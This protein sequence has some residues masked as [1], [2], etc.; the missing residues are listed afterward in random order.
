[1]TTKKMTLTVGND[2]GNAAHKMIINGDLIKAP[3]VFSKIRKLPN[4]EELSFDYLVNNLDKN[5]IVSIETDS[6]NNGLPATYLIAEHAISSGQH[7]TNMEVR[8]GMTKLDS[9]VPIVNTNAQI[10]IYA[11]KYALAENPDIS[12]IQTEIYMVT[13][14]PVLQN[15]VE[16]RKR[17]ADKFYGK[18]NT[19]VTVH[20]KERKIKVHIEY[21]Y[22]KVLHENVS[23]IWYLQAIDKHDIKFKEF[24]T[25][26][27]NKTAGKKLTGDYFKGKKILMVAPGDGTCEYVVLNDVQF[28]HHLLD[29]S[30]NGL[31]H[32]IEKVLPDFKEANRLDV[33]TRQDFSK[34]MTDKSARYHKLVHEYI[35]I[36]L[37]TE[38]VEILA[39]TASLVTKA[40]NDIDMIVVHGGSSIAMAEH[41]KEKFYSNFEPAIEVLY[42][43]SEIAVEIEVMGQYEFALSPIFK[44]LVEQHLE[45]VGVK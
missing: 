24:E 19:T 2:N 25:R 34:A 3:N 30:N 28:D 22:I 4:Q 36:G 35:E 40:K 42:V 38:S 15:N 12:D 37:E 26:Y 13:A 17:F 21:K 44:T 32:A 29:G 41:L 33:F 23:P 1:M 7:M 43:P 9:D 16:N 8:P 20:I 45:R 5:I 27:K 31:G 14:L 6:V 39:K 18:N 11:A 10:A